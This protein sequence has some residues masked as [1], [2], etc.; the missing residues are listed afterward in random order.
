[1]CGSHYKNLFVQLFLNSSAY[2]TL[3]FRILK[4]VR[5]TC[6]D[7][8]RGTE[9]QNDPA[10]QG[11]KDPEGGFAIKLPRRN[12]DPSSTQVSMQMNFKWTCK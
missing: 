11:K 8:Y 7:W 10:M 12:V 2:F 9:P 5:D 6:A 4:S 1:M 3:W